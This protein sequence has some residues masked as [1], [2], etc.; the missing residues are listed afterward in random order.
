MWVEKLGA[1]AALVALCR[2]ANVKRTGAVLGWVGEGDMCR[3]LIPA[4]ARG[5]ARLRLS[6]QARAQGQAGGWKRKRAGPC[7][8][9]VTAAARGMG[10]QYRLCL[11]LC[12]PHGSRHYRA[13]TCR[14]YS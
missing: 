9:C 3:C 10:S 11:L 8:P 7:V 12:L 2:F 13:I 1:R 14:V 6:E 4:L 5:F